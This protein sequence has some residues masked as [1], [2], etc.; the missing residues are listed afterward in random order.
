MI[1]MKP[2]MAVVSKAGRDK[3]ELFLILRME[4]EYAYIVDG[5]L[6]KVDK[7]KKKKLKHLQRIDYISEFISA[8]LDN[9]DRVTNSEVRKALAQYRE[10]EG[11]HSFG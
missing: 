4:G 11:G 2:A 7:P 10:S 9:G 3:G 6:R 5:Q 1:E 8:K